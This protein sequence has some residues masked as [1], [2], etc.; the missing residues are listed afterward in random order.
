VAY[1][2]DDAGATAVIHSGVFNDALGDV[3]LKTV[4][5]P[6]STAPSRGELDFHELVRTAE[7][8][9]A[10]AP[11]EPDDPAW[12]F[13]TSGTTGRPK[14][15]MITHRMLTSMTG[16]YFVDVCDLRDDDVVLHAA[17]LTHGSGLY[18][19]PAV[20][21]GA[22]SVVLDS[23]S[24]DPEVFFETVRRWRVTVVAFLAPTQI[25]KLLES[26]DPARHDMTSV[27]SI[28]YGGGPAYVGHLQAAMNAWGPVL[29]QIYGQGEAPMSITCLTAA[30]HAT[31]GSA[32]T[33]G[34]LSSAGR[35][36][37]GTEVSVL[38]EN[39]RDCPPGEVGEVCARGDVVMASYWNNPA[40][41]D[42][43][44]HGGWLHTG[45]IGYLDSSGYLFLLDR[46]KDVIV[47][48]GSNVYPREVEEALLEHPEILGAC[49]FAVPD[50]YWGEAVH[51]V[52]VRAPGSSLDTNVVKAHCRDWLADY[53][54]PRSVEF[55]GELPKNAYGK[56]LKRELRDPYWSGRERMIGGGGLP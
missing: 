9:P 3:E 5:T 24:F 47:T 19:L 29:V 41:T 4:N 25:V 37:F 10:A 18:A 32:E 44:M 20:T 46:S 11:V 38:D 23:A 56:V 16:A 54:Q 34:P 50:D 43:S 31:F 21:K 17:P 40:A 12:L 53:K 1:I 13:Y 55:R 39:G 15:V 27:R 14:G 22:T 28:C 30:D 36:Q 42:Q 2:A 6:V 33:T 48:G 45:D 26:Y 8:L 35:A 7:P 52:V 49:V 51:A